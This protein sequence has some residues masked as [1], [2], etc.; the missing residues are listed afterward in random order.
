MSEIKPALS[1][2]EWG[3]VP[4]LFVEVGCPERHAF[5]ARALHGQP[6]G[7]TWEDVDTLRESPPDESL[8]DAIADRVAALLPPREP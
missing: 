8:L 1:P 7:F 2:E 3:A 5:A 4:D 6:F